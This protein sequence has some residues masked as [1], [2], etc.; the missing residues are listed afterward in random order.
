MRAL[1][2][3]QKQHISLR[4]IVPDEELGDNDVQIEIKAV[5][6]CGSDIH[7]YQHGKIGP[8]IVDK[9][10]ILGHEAAG[11]V[12]ATGK[13]VHHLRCGDRVC[14]EPG[15]P[16][17]SSWQSRV[18]RY[19]LDPSVRFWATPPV[20]GCLRESVI[21]PAALTY[22]LPDN[23]SFTQGAMVEPLAVGVHAVCQAS[24]KP[25]DIALVTGAGPIGMMTAVAALAAGCSDVIVSDVFD[26]KLAFTHHYPGL[27]GVNVRASGALSRAV[28]HL[29]DGQGADVI[30]ECS[31]ALPALGSLPEYAS[32]GATVVLVGMPVETAPMDIVAAQAKEITF[33]TLF[34]YVNCY[35]RT[36]RLLSRGKLPVDALISRRYPFED[37]VEAFRYA[38]AGHPEEMKIVITF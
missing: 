4:D 3:E 21:H 14:M 2:L 8:F 9:P 12:T 10:M 20:H 26:E 36:L 13:N 31:G 27:H 28:A 6:I 5:G 25:G 7:Y 19:N 24:I 22:K 34:R 15:I 1:V 30:F 32:P 33:K 37:S 11:V 23:V 16:D 29:T 18:G 38:A 17:F 35:P